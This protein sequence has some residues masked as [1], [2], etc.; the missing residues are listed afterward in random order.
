MDFKQPTVEDYKRMGLGRFIVDRSS[1]PNFYVSSWNPSN[2]LLTV[3]GCEGKY[4][5]PNLNYNSVMVT[6]PSNEYAEGAWW[7]LQNLLRYT[8]E[9]GYLMALEELDDMS[10]MPADAIGIMRACA[11]KMALDARFQ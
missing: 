7:R 9:Q 8:E 5:L 1:H 2:G 4:R 3:A 10:T 11:S 6:V